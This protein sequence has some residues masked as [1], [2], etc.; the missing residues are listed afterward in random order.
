MKFVVYAH[1]YRLFWY[2]QP[3]D[4]VIIPQKNGHKSPKDCLWEIEKIQHCNATT[5]II[6]LR[7]GKPILG[8]ETLESF[9]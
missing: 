2:L 9:K 7:T 8:D 1:T 3:A 6:N 5:P 4:G